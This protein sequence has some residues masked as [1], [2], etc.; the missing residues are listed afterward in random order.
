[1]SRESQTIKLEDRHNG[2]MV[3]ATLF[4]GI[5]DDNL[6]EYN[7]VWVPSLR[8]AI[9]RAK[10][11]LSQGKAV[12]HPAEDSHWDW[13]GKVLETQGS[14]AHKHFAVECEGK[15]QGLMQLE[16]SLHR[17][18]VEV[19]QHLVYVDYLS[20]APWN[21]KSIEPKPR[22]RGV[23]SALLAQAIGTSAEEG[24]FGRLGLHSLPNAA[25]WYRK[26]FGMQS[27][28]PD[29]SKQGLEYFELTQESAQQF[30]TRLT[31]E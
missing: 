19:G 31:E 30:L 8:E 2:K 29:A 10:A 1:M 23:G 25:D 9:A 7:D 15:T 4:E 5:S 3:D 17:S 13:S 24:F 26:E 22:F 14:L 28:G 20:V 21:R 16:L 6:R 18:R 27:F 11:L 12:S